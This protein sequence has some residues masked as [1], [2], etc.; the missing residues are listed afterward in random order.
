[1][2][3][4]NPDLS[5]SE[6]RLR[7]FLVEHFPE[8]RG[9]VFPAEGSPQPLLLLQLKRE[10]A[11]FALSNGNP[12]RCYEE[13]YAFFKKIYASHEREWDELNLTFIFCLAHRDRE[14]EAFR[15]EIETNVFFCRKFT[16]V[17]DT[18]LQFEAELARLPFFPLERKEGG[19]K[20]PPS[21]QTLLKGSGVRAALAASIAGRRSEE[22]IVEGCLKGLFGKPELI[23]TDLEHEPFPSGDIPQPIQL[24]QVEI[25]NF[26]AYRTPQLFDLDADLVLLNGPNGLGKTSLFD[27]VDF[28]ATGDIGRLRLA[29][30][31]PRFNKAATHLDALP[32]ESGH[33]TLTFHAHDRA[34]EIHR[35]VQERNTPSLDGRSTDRKRVLLALSG[36]V[37]SPHTEHVDHLVRLFRATHLFGQES[38]TLT[39][40][41]R[42]HCR[43]STE[44]VSRML[45]FEDYVNAGR[46]VSKVVDLLSKRVGQRDG[47]MHELIESLRGRR[48][49]LAQL[50]QT[51]RR[52]ESPQGVDA[53]RGSVRGRLESA[54]IEL[55]ADPDPV[56]EVRGWRALLEA[57]ISN[58]RALGNR[59]S[60]LAEQAQV[61]ATQ[62]AQLSAQQSQHGETKAR[63]DEALKQVHDLRDAVSKMES[64]LAAMTEREEGLRQRLDTLS[65]LRETKPAYDT[66]I[67][68]NTTLNGEIG[69]LTRAL[70][71]Q[72]R[73]LEKLAGDLDA[74]ES[75]LAETRARSET[76][77][78][79]LAA[80]TSLTE[81]YP[82]WQQQV[83]RRHELEQDVT[84]KRDLIAKLEH[85]LPEATTV[86]GDAEI[87]EHRAADEMNRIESTQSDLQNVLTAIERHVVDAHCP[88][89]GHPY[90]SKDEML[91][92][93]RERRD[94]SALSGE[95]T[96]RLQQARSRL[97]ALKARVEE[98]RTRLRN[99]QQTMRASTSEL[100]TI[101][102]EI[103]GFEAL[104][105][106]LGFDPTEV[107]LLEHIRE[108]QTAAEG[109]ANELVQ[110]LNLHVQFAQAA[111]DA[112]KAGRA[113]V[114]TRQRDLTAKEHAL[115]EVVSRAT[116]IRSEAAR[117]Q[118]TLDS[119]VHMIAE[120]ESAARTEA[121][122]ISIQISGKQTGL[123]GQ[124]KSLAE[125]DRRAETLKRDL[126]SQDAT[127]RSIQLAIERYE[128]DLDASGFTRQ[129][130]QA[131][132]RAKAEEEL[133]RVHV[134]E[135]L[136]QNVTSLEM[137]LDAAA[138]SAAAGQVTIH[139][140]AAENELATLN[141]Q[142]SSDKVW[143]K[144]F[145]DIRAKLQQTQ[146]RSVKNYTEKYGPI[147]SVIQR[148]LR[149]VSGF[150]DI[151]LHPEGG[152]INVRV[153]RNGELLPPTDFFSQSQQ[154]ILILSLFLTACTTQT[155]SAFA[156]ILL[157]DPVT[158]FDDLNVYSFLDLIGGFLESDFPIRQFIVSTCDDRFFQLAR[159]RFQ[160]LGD[161]GRFYQFVSSGSGGPVIEDCL[162]LA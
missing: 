49:E 104:A 131:Q 91:R 25:E 115:E 137:A 138:T 51:V 69:T 162:G 39:D 74:A 45:A 161:R 4:S 24:L 37:E 113:E 89:C 6:E 141:E 112:F 46:K 116:R 35:T 36:A 128:A 106:G 16:V 152:D 98:S 2:P 84:Q 158:H 114:Q 147:T 97:T 75:R 43:L 1:M 76:N 65:W 79:R 136:K 54:G 72:S 148:R 95:A 140:R 96:A 153:T 50:E 59:L 62:R 15:A 121:K 99:A 87:E 44:V 11:G 81:R 154:Q 118:V 31:G 120:G 42:E 117:R 61:V 146:E 29:R 86:I 70:A 92:R 71:D 34:H 157:D 160:Y 30:E 48:A 127:I 134:L 93:L 20:R 83:A 111:R 126:A 108:Q 122:E 85:D 144:F 13:S 139:I 125:L 94:V 9:R 33:V 41:F 63:L 102:T 8:P 103:A 129:A 155:W 101:V 130:Q 32:S 143:I 80:I 78:K 66:L 64:D 132:I 12:H 124:R 142:Q 58:A 27:A 105:H 73:P 133:R 23:A 149:S 82:Y 28:A 7:Q 19:F 119:D 40:D 26:R 53:L 56:A 123:S 100:Q 22:T 14:L 151:S 57:L 145:E 18:P 47:Q 55:P 52:A 88:A 10:L 67:I 77:A 5:A 60:R 135:E 156:P 68:R 3:D 17:L 109:A 90:E 110:A 159:Q 21:A 107:G 150:E 38:Q